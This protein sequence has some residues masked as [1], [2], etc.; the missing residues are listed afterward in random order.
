MPRKRTER[1]NIRLTPYEKVLITLKMQES[2]FSNLTEYILHC[3]NSNNTVVVDTMPI[4]EVKTE[5]NRI[6]NNVN[7]IAKTANANGYLSKGTIDMLLSDMQEMKDTVNSGFDALKK[8]SEDIGL[9]EN[10][11]Y[12][13]KHAS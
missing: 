5:L 6:G 1:Y 2:G 10:C 9:C 4:M 8:G 13:A 12:K 11:T 3:I 7:Q